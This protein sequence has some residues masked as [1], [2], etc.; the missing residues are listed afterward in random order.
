MKTKLSVLLGLALPLI[1]ISQ[2]W[3]PNAGQNALLTNSR[4]GSGI[5]LGPGNIQPSGLPT[6]PLPWAQGP[7]FTTPPSTPQEFAMT[8]ISKLNYDGMM[9][10]THPSMTQGNVVIRLRNTT[11][12]SQINRGHDWQIGSTGVN[13]GAGAGNFVIYDVEK[14]VCGAGVPWLCGISNQNNAPYFMIRGYNST[15]PLT[16]G[17]VGI[18]EV[19][20]QNRLQIRTAIPNTSGLRFSD[21]TSTSPLLANP[22]LGVLSLDQNGDVI[23]VNAGGGNAGPGLGNICQAVQNP[24]A[25]HYEIPLNSFDFNFSGDSPNRNKVN[26]GYN[27][28]IPTNGKFNVSTAFQSDPNNN[29]SY[30]IHS[31]NTNG[32]SSSKNTAVYGE[33]NAWLV[34][35]VITPDQRGVWGFASGEG[36]SIGVQGEAEHAANVGGAGFA[37]YGGYFK[38]IT[39]NPSTNYGIY[40]E[41]ANGQI[42][43]GN[44]AN[45]AG[46]FV[47]D[48]NV[49][50]SGWY[51][52]IWVTSDRKYKKDIEKLGNVT[53]KLQRLSGYTYNYNV[54][55]FKAKNFDKSEQIGLIAQEVKEVFPQLVKEDDKGLL[56]VNYQGMIPVLLEAAKE[57]QQ[58]IEELKALVNSLIAN[59]DLEN[60]VGTNK[61]TLVEL[62]D[63]NAIVLNQ[64]VPNP[65]AESTV[66]SYNIPTDFTKAQILFSTNDGKVIRTID[67]TEK[68]A[69][70]LNVFA[71]DLTHGLYTYSL[72]VDGKTIDTKKMIKQ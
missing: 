66:I 23:Y 27:C 29:S 13:D 35:G 14:P 45:W 33:A 39:S 32:G 38:A 59:T 25:G 11:F 63:K 51:G 54:E 56:S 48:V 43:N 67:I 10:A 6:F 49:S 47:G 42:M 52:G 44:S 41:A 60:K 62:S 7:S 8:V 24:L 65:F 64:N 37:A 31:L 26:V 2:S 18:N 12:T 71:N 3:I 1:S 68:G 17:Y 28:G 61:N 9:V 40:A 16:G 34:Q 4:L 55:Q 21:L 22:G 58:Q 70:N 30:S 53:G 20:P 19:N 72:V 46:Y 57:Q 69:S 50:G 36:N 15:S 5:M